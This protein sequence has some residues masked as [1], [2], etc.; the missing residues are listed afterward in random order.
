MN[1]DYDERYDGPIDDDSINRS[2]YE[3]RKVI[4]KRNEEKYHENIKSQFKND[5]EKY[6]RTTM[7]GALASIEKSDFGRLFGAGKKVNELTREEKDWRHEW[8]IVRTEIL[9]KGHDQCLNALNELSELS[10]KK[11]MYKTEFIV[12][13]NRD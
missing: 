1:K 4:Q 12:K 5:L 6:F 8:D 3:Q 7:I 10:V 11:H 9:D 2:L 13:K